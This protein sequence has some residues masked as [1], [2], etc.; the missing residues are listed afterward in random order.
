MI[1]G[2]TSTTIASAGVWHCPQTLDITVVSKEKITGCNEAQI[3]NLVAGEYQ[4]AR[5]SGEG[6][7]IF[8]GAGRI[9]SY[10]SPKIKQTNIKIGCPISICFSLTSKSK[11][12]TMSWG[13]AYGLA[14]LISGSDPTSPECNYSPFDIALTVQ[15]PTVDKPKK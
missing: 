13:T 9:C 12:K 1:L 8:K 3:S 15:A 4:G 5:Y 6:A 10:T 11:E 2:F 14:K 7:D